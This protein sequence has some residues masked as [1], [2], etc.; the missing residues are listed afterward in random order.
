M[1]LVAAGADRRGFPLCDAFNAVHVLGV[2]LENVLVTSGAGRLLDRPDDLY[3]A[4]GMGIV[5][6]RAERSLVVS[7]LDQRGMQAILVFLERLLV[8][9]PAG[10]AH[11]DGIGPLAFDRLL[12]LAVG[13]RVDIRVTVLAIGLAVLR[14]LEG[15][16]GNVQGKLLLVVERLLLA[17][18]IVAFQAGLGF[19]RKLVL[20][21]VDSAG[22]EE[23]QQGC[24]GDHQILAAESPDRLAHD[25]GPA[26][27]ISP[28]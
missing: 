18:L 6:I 3:R 14:L 7:R 12:D 11:G 16:G 4:Q 21:R 25:R 15:L 5:A 8:A 28:K 27:R 17:L 19:F 13:L 22:Q 20:F 1:G 2:G 26:H 24:A 23:R 10:S 9:F